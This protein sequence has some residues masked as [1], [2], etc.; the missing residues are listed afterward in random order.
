MLSCLK[1]CSVWNRF[2]LTLPVMLI[3]SSRQ[4]SW[5]LRQIVPSNNKCASISYWYIMQP[6]TRTWINTKKKVSKVTHP[7]E[8]HTEVVSSTSGNQ[9]ILHGFI[10][11]YQGK[12]ASACLRHM[13]YSLDIGC[14]GSNDIYTAFPP[15]VDAISSFHFAVPILLLR[16]NP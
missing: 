3:N 12:L 7:F 11:D 10:S 15:T 9:S 8:R 2:S 13:V 4:A 16:T 1:H 14:L 5:Q 6:R